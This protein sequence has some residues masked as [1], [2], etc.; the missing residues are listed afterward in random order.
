MCDGIS[1]AI[2]DLYL[3]E[4]PESRL[5]VDSVVTTDRL[6][7]V[8]EFRGPVH[9]QK[10]LEGVARSVVR[11]IGYAQEGFDWRTFRFDNFL[12]A[13][14]QDIARGV[15]DVHGK[16]VGAGDQ[17][18]MFGYAI[19][20]TPELMPAPIMYAHRLMEKVAAL[21]KSGEA[22]FLGPDAK[23]Q[24]SLAY[25]DGKPFRASCVVISSQHDADVSPEQVRSC[26]HSVA[27][28]V[29]P[30]S[31]MCSPE[32]FFVN[33]T[34]RFVIGGPLGDSGLTGRKNV[35]DTY[36]GAAP[37]GGGS[38][39]G[40]DPSKLDRTGA[41]M[42]R[43]LAKNVVAAGLAERCTIQISFAIGVSRPLSF[44][45]NGHGT[46]KIDEERIADVLQGMVD[47]S[48]RGMRDHLQLGKPMYKRTAVYGHFG[49]SPQQDG[50]FSW[51]KTDLA[52][53]LRQAFGV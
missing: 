37:H 12:H 10:E 3:G 44:C 38:F 1:D 15:D 27:C 32:Q 46:A 24:V 51:E 39:S 5:A 8:G 40:K 49:R 21:R 29:F 47:L 23:S 18:S 22:D 35:V 2:V 20:E 53:S 43:Y 7:L 16:L 30:S 26:L 31:W 13:Q 9:L 19:R 36:G 45:L 11:E 17:G 4:E 52:D 14:S 41:Y 33:P 48:P 50:G 25:R 6:I 34:G 28:E 42:A